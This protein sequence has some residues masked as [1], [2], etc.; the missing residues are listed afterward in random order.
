MIRKRKW[1]CSFEKNI[2]LRIFDNKNYEEVCTIK[3]IDCIKDTNCLY[4]Y[5]NEYIIISCHNGI[6]LGQA[7]TKELIQ[8]IQKFSTI[9]QKICCGIN[10]DNN[11]YILNVE[12]NNTNNVFQSSGLFGYNNSC[13]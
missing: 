4:K 5:N 6:G 3:N 11:L 2:D 9:N 8:Y 1:I 12:S 7:R 10:D 13:S